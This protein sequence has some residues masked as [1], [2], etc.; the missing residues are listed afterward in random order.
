[1][2]ERIAKASKV[3]FGVRLGH[4]GRVAVCELLGCFVWF[5]EGH[6]N[7][8]IAP[9]RRPLIANCPSTISMFLHMLGYTR[10]TAVERMEAFHD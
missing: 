4:L 7:E 6:K 2:G 3:P 9:T 8:G 1:M 10:S 5:T